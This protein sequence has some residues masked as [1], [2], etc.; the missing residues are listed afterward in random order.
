MAVW[1]VS[2]RIRAKSGCC[3]K[4]IPNSPDSWSSG[5]S[6]S[7][8]TARSW[9]SGITA[10]SGMTRGRIRSCLWTMECPRSRP[11]RCLP[12]QRARSGLPNPEDWSLSSPMMSPVWQRTLEPSW[13][14][15]RTP[16]AVS[17]LP[18][19]VTSCASSL[20]GRRPGTGSRTGWTAALF[21]NGPSCV[22]PTVICISAAPLASASSIRPRCRFQ[23]SAPAPISPHLK[24]PGSRVRPS[25]ALP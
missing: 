1:A 24:W 20:P 25:P 22:T 6:P 18:P 23:I 17:G 12:I 8:R 4:V 7:F 21:S 9:R 15:P 2:I 19:S 11:I 3:G 16:M 5:M 13:V 14:S 10:A